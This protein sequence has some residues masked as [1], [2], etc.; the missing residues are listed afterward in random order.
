[1]QTIIKKYLLKKHLWGGVTTNNK[2]YLEYSFVGDDTQNYAID[3]Q[4]GS[5]KLIASKNNNNIS[6]KTLDDIILEYHF[7]PNFIKIDTDGFDF[8]VLRSAESTLISYK[9]TLYFEWDKIHLQTQGENPL[10]I[11]DYLHRLGYEKCIIYDNFGN[12]FCIV[13]S[14][15]STNLSLLLDY[16]TISNQNIYYYDV[17]SFH[18]DSGLNYLDF[19]NNLKQ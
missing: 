11:F 19:L 8:R 12:M 17:L 6:I 4:D 7:V 15:D 3:L 2:F 18:K 16:T 9:P 14:K 5:G 13:E 1:M 10:S